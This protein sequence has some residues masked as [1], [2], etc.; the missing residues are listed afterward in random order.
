[1]ADVTMN[2]KVLNVTK[3]TSQW[4]ENSVKD[5]IISKGL[6]C[7]EIDTNNKS[8]VKI[9]DGVNKFA[10]LPYI[11]DGAI[12]SLGDFLRVKGT[13]ASFSQLPTTG[14][15]VGDVYFVGDS[16]TTGSDKFEEYV[17]TSG[18]TWEFIG[19]I[20][21]PPTYTSGTGIS[22][23][24]ENVIN[25]SNSVTQQ[26][27]T[28]LKK[29]SWDAQGHIT[30]SDTVTG[31]D[32][33]VATSETAGVVKV[34]TNLS[35]SNGVLS[36]TDT[37]YTF[38]GTYNASTNKAATVSTVTNAINALD[39]SDITGFGAGK[40]LA[41][42]TETDGKIAATFQ[43][44]SIANTQVTGLGDAATK[45][46]TDNTTATAVTSTDQN[47]ITGRTLYNAGYTKNIGTVTG[48]TMNSTSKTVDAN[49]VVDLGTVITDVS[50]KADV[51]TTVTNV[52]YNTT[53]AKL[54]ETINGTTSDI[55][56]LDTTPTSASKK[57]ITSGAVYTALE[58]KVDT[59]DSLILNC[60]L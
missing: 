56:T 33:P 57:P 44:I 26:A 5:T 30:G 32:L 36:A 24:N 31:A 22:I 40:T 52:S 25:H 1:M 60:T 8:W 23:T 50:G 49:G 41:T 16:S 45:G 11:T 53:S 58:S 13:V 29:V 59:T 7:V 4:A 21:N 17:W 48:I 39:V 10:D 28:S 3:T 14:N 27:T 6:L 2:A 43:N 12:G 46:V 20:S 34:G 37:T 38:D 18:G 19:K 15:K 51:S 55:V 35:I 54:Q 47:L 42:L 9:G